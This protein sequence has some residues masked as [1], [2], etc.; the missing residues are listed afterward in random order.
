[1]FGGPLFPYIDLLNGVVTFAPEIPEDLG[2]MNIVWLGG[3]VTRAGT[4]MP[5]L[6]VNED[7]LSL[8]G[9]CPEQI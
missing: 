6:S 9:D 2:L 5:A 4:V 3:F 1:M 7:E 8:K